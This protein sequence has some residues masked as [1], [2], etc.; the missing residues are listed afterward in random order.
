MAYHAIAFTISTTSSVAATLPTTN[1]GDDVWALISIDGTGITFG[2]P[3]GWAASGS[4]Q[5]TT[6]DGQTAQLF[7]LTAG[8]PASPPA[9]ATWT[10]TGGGSEIGAALI[11]FSGRQIGN[12][13]FNVQSIKN[14]STATPFTASLTGGTASSNDDLLVLLATDPPSAVGTITMS[15]TGTPGTF[16][17]RGTTKG[18]GSFSPVGVSTIN[19]IA[20]G[21][22]GSISAAWTD[23]NNVASAWMGWVVAIKA[24]R[25]AMFFGADC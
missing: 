6:T 9:T 8:A 22:T 24:A 2:A 12:T 19:N 1:P 5:S 13:S 7:H 17:N 16:A 20:P 14:S 18:G 21:A 23:T 15:T 25:D 4:S 3:T 10:S 11:S